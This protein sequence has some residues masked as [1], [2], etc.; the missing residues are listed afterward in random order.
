[1][2]SGTN[3]CKSCRQIFK[4]CGILTVTSLSI[5]EVLC[6]TKRYKGSLKQTLFI[7]GY[8]TRRKVNLHVEFCNTVPFQKSVVNMGIKHVTKYRKV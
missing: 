3:K 5:L 6:Y 2:I 8:N 7:H 1:M 4:D